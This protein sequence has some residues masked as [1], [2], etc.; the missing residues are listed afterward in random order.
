MVRI[1]FTDKAFDSIKNKFCEE[2]VCFL[3]PKIS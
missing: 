3:K 2:K 1:E